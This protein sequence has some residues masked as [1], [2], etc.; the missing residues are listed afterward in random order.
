M[1]HDLSAPSPWFVRHAD[2]VA[3]GE[4]VLDVACGSGRHAKFFAARGALVTAVDRDAI[5]LSTLDAQPSITALCADLE[6]APWPFAPNTFDAVIVCNYLWRPTLTA[7][8][9]TIKPSGLLIYETFMDGN[10][11]FGKP[12]RP[13]FLLRSNELLDITRNAFQIISFVEGIDTEPLAVKQRICARKH[14]AP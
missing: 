4:T 10:E 13:D 8:L 5:A 12:S 9:D 11:Q 6:L 1:Q 7:L 14:R 2:F 3:A